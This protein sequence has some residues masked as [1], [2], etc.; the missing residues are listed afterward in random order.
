MNAIEKFKAKLPWLFGTH[1]KIERF[2]VIFFLL[3]VC[4]V[5]SFG[6]AQKQHMDAMA[7]QLGDQVMYTTAFQMSVSHAPCEVMDIRVSEDKTKCFI[8]LGRT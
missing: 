1:Y 8:M 6:F 3:L 7:V 4:L 2:G 5:S